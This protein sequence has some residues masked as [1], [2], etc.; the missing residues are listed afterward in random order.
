[1]R[2]RPIRLA[3]ALVVAGSLALAA[4]GDDD[5]RWVEFGFARPI[6]RRTPPAVTGLVLR[7]GGVPGEI[8]A[9]WEPS[10][11]ATNYRVVRQVLTVDSDPVEVGLFTDRLVAISGLPIGQSVTVSVTARN[12]VGETLPTN[13]VIVVA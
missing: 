2:A 13:S 1:M 10:V 5:P 9:E 7:P 3:F 11:G 8:I 6:D 12:Q 4:C